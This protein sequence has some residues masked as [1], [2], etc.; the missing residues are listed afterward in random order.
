MNVD[1]FYFDGFHLL[2]ESATHPIELLATRLGVLLLLAGSSLA[3]SS[4]LPRRAASSPLGRVQ[5]RNLG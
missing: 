5:L 4:R 1:I 2:G 3:A